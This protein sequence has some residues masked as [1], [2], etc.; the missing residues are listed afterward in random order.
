MRSRFTAFATGDADYLITTWDPST[1]PPELTLDS[2]LRWTLLEITDRVGGGPLDP[3]GI[4]A[5][6]AHY[7]GP[8]GAGRLVE[9]SRFRRVDRHWYYL[10]G[11]LGQ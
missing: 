5:F 4:V 8:H 7:R 11:E 2:D 3:T 6:V 1:R 10:D 9:R